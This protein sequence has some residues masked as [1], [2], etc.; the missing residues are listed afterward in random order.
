M[1]KYLQVAEKNY[2]SR[3]NNS[4]GGV[5][6]WPSR[7]DSDFHYAGPGSVPGWA[8]ENPASCEA[9]KKKKKNRD[10]PLL[11]IS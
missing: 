1:S 5:P 10:T 9:K 11:I 6:W 3:S 8:T 4:L 2:S 7:Q